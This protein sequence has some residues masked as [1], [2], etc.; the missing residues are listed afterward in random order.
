MAGLRSPHA[1]WSCLPEFYDMY[2]PAGVANAKHPT[3]PP[4]APDI[5]WIH[6]FGVKDAAGKSYSWNR[7]TP[8][9]HDI[10]ALNR[11]AYYACVSMADYLLGTVMEEAKKLGV[12][13]DT[14]TVFQ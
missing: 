11:R 14:I 12:W 8:V 10:E 1:P 4:T 5:A 3:F 9:P 7:T 2:D 6:N 13:N